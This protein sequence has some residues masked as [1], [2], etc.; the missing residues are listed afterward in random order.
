M[1]DTLH[2]G[3]Y[4]QSVHSL[5]R[6]T[7]IDRIELKYL[8]QQNGQLVNMLL[9]YRQLDVWMERTVT[10]DW[11]HRVVKLAKFDYLNNHPNYLQ[12]EFADQKRPVAYHTRQYN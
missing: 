10:E 5:S 6:L 8:V 2:A 12:Q 4:V 1:A 7:S 11:V 3:T 9:L